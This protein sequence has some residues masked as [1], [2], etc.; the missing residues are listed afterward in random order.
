LGEAGVVEA[1]GV[2][3]C[4][5]SPKG[6]SRGDPPPRPGPPPLRPRALRRPVPGRALLPAAGTHS[7]PPI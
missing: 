7:D 5:A 3:V 2:V 6:R 1:E 4:G